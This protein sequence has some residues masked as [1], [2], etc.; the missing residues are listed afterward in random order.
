M[1]KKTSPKTKFILKAVATSLCLKALNKE[2][3]AKI[4]EQTDINNNDESSNFLAISLIKPSLAGFLKLV[5]IAKL[6]KNFV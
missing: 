2:I 4:N 5:F 1:I 6:G 3:K